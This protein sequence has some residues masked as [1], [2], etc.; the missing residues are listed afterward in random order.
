MAPPPVTPGPPPVDRVDGQVGAGGAGGAPDDPYG[1][2]AGGEGAAGPHDALIGGGLGAQ[3]DGLDEDPVEVHVG[4]RARGV[5]RGDPVEPGAVE[6]DVDGSA[7]GVGAGVAVGGGGGLLQGAPL[8]LVGDGWVG[9]VVA[10]GRR[11]RGRRGGC[12]WGGEG[13]GAS[14]DRGG[15]RYGGEARDSGSAEGGKGE[16]YCDEDEAGSGKQ[17]PAGH[18]YLHFGTL[19]VSTA[20]ARGPHA[21]WYRGHAEPPLARYARYH[22]AGGLRH[23]CLAPSWLSYAP[24]RR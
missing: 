9:L 11:G 8:A 20:L 22:A 6:G 3:V 13:R 16:E 18:T 7:G 2:R 17:K 23:R 10:G 15:L 12:C 4:H 1:V 24:R 5:L 19:P 14:G 21:T